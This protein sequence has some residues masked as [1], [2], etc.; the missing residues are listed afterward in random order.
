MPG[1]VAQ[2]LLE[3]GASVEI[4]EVILLI[5]AMRTQQPIVAPLTGVVKS[6]WVEVGQQVA[7]EQ[8][9]ARIVE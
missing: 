4:G 3:A 1:L 2:V 5:E 7:E 9:L 6:A 8:I